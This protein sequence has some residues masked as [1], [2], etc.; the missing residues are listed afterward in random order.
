M[1]DLA[2]FLNNESRPNDTTNVVSLQITTTK[3]TDT[4]SN[5]NITT[6]KKRSSTSTIIKNNKGPLKNPYL[7]TFPTY[8]QTTLNLNLRL[9]LHALTQQP[10]PK[11][12]G[13]H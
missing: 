7:N 13:T 8:T 12:H 11:R 1:T 9:L 4:T 10:K 3:D 5:K 6:N 2:P